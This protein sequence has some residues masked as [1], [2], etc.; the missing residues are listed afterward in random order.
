M[1]LANLL[2]H[3]DRRFEV[4]V[5]ATHRPVL[6]LMASTRPGIDAH[7]LAPIASRRDHEAIRGHFR[8]LAQVKPDIL[9]VSLNR[10]WGS[11]WMIVAGLLARGVRV[12]AVEHSPRRSPRLVHRLYV[13]V[14]ARLLAAQVA[15]TD[16]SAAALAELAGVRRDRITT[17]SGGVADV[18]IESLARPTTGPV[19]GCIARLDAIKGIDVL[20]RALPSLPGVTTVIVG[21]GEEQRSLLALA[22]ELGVAERVIF[23]GWSDRPRDHLGA[24]DLFVLPSRFEALP[25]SIIEAM[26][27]GLP[28]VATDVGGVREAVVPGVTGSLVE[29][30]NP[31]ALAGAISVLLAD[32]QRRRQLGQAGRERALRRFGADQMASQFAMLYERIAE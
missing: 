32:P 20:L 2:A 29:P 21:S 13:R 6:E 17:I 25:M 26:F 23:I 16:R 30:E 9:Q 3:L 5:A 18:R 31:E 19:I 11:Q 7:A 28:V 12:V 14:S 15:L 4:S 24:F 8:L 22:A 1:H 27:A 10:P